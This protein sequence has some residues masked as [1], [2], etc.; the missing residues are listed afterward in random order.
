MSSL[1]IRY[2]Y[3]SFQS[4]TEI[5]I[6]VLQLTTS[7]RWLL[8]QVESTNKIYLDL[9]RLDQRAVFQESDYDL[10]LDYL[11]NRSWGGSIF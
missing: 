6:H 8:E 1:Y 4:C 2:R 5:K 3:S 10:G 7:L 9:E 11:S